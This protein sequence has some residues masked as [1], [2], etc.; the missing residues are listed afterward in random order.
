MGQFAALVVALDGP[1]ENCIDFI[2]V[3]PA[4]GHDSCFRVAYLS[5][6]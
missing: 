4:F 3:V 6:S 5:R 1:T 2:L